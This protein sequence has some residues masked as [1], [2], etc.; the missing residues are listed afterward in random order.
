LHWEFWVFWLLHLSTRLARMKQPVARPLK[1]KQ[2]VQER[3]T[4]RHSGLH[5][6][7]PL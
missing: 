1:K 5:A 3:V 4:L 6:S 7:K 2:L